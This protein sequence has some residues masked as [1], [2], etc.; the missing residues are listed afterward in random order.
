MR[1]GRW[2][3]GIDFGTLSARG[4]LVEA[5]TGKELASAVS[6]YASGV[7]DRALPG[8]KR[9][10][11]VESALQDPA[12]YLEAVRVIVRKLLRTTGG[13]AEEVAGI[14]TDF[15]SC[16]VVACEKDGRPVCFDKRWRSNPHA[17]VKLWKHHAAQPEADIINEVA[18]QRGEDFLA[19]YGGKYS[20]E[21]LVSKVLETARK[22]PEVY[23]AAGRFI[24]ACDW[25]VWQLTGEER[26]N[27][28]AAGFKGMRVAGGEANYPENDFFEALDPRLD[29]FIREKV[30]AEIIPL[31][32]RAGGLSAAWAKATGLKEGTAVCSGNID[33][34]AGVPGVGVT[35]AGKLVMIMGTSTCHLLIDEKRRL[36][37]GI[38]GVVKDGIV[39]GAYGY[40]AGQ[41][42]VG[43]MFAWF[44]RNAAPGKVTHE[45]LEKEAARQKPGASGLVALDWWNGNR[46]VLVDA[47]LSGA[48]VGLK[49][50]TSAAQIYR[51]LLESTAFGTRK[52]V[53]TFQN[54]GV[55][56]EEVIACGGLPQKNKLLMQ[57][58]ADVLG[59]TIVVPNEEQASAKGAAM[60]A[61]VAAGV[62]G[63]IHAAARAMA[64]RGK[65]IYQPRTAATKIYDEIYGEY[66]ELHDY[67]GRAQDGVMKR[68]SRRMHHE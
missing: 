68:L 29:G 6:E 64:V 30:E 55:P 8:S 23:R 49:L 42:G 5:R 15:T 9:A 47:D 37:E 61:A 40:E 3:I 2:L 50:S 25:I 27:V 33:A 67:F 63:D 66:S 11:A 22:A 14:G 13:K 31:S 32:A 62:Y 17:W 35:T 53:E 44:M 52:I 38:C 54:G 16:T 34:H 48:L 39:T 20:S 26:R 56:I 28:S 19:V 58:Y 1:Q 43:D 60:H 59:R 4:L 57:I 18:R 24:E 46:S 10:L 41:P 12:D 7:M 36:V 21:W 65:T 51:A 45:T